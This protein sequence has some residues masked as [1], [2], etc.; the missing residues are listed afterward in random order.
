MS[1]GFEKL[2]H[3]SLKA[4]STDFATESL[5]KRTSD[6]TLLIAMPNLRG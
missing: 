4:F 6:A 5:A 3:D 2:L 1:Q